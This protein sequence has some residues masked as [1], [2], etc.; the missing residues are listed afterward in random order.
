MSEDI[1][2][3]ATKKDAEEFLALMKTAFKPLKDLGIEWPS[4]NVGL[5][6]VTAN[7]VNSTAYVLE[8]DGEI[9]STI[10]IKFPWEAGINISGY[11]FVWWFA[12][13][14]EY[15][16]QGVGDKLLTYVEE[17]ILRDTLKAPAV[18][19]GTSLKFHPWLKGIY[20]RRGYTVYYEREQEYGD[21]DGLMYKV[22]IPE[23]FDKEV[24][25]VPVLD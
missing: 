10:T 15:K 18:V 12:T 6:D 3:V 23:N 17:T 7:I 21:V 8:R 5:E 22:L 11:P 24:L 20:E 4:V 1:I 13:K 25:G 2:R 16:G 14:P 9:I 19:L